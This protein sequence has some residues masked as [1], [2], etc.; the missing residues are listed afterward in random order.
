MF[1]MLNVV[2]FTNARELLCMKELHFLNA[3]VT[4]RSSHYHHCL[5]TDRLV[6]LIIHIEQLPNPKKPFWWKQPLMTMGDRI[7]FGPSV[8]SSALIWDGSQMKS[9]SRSLGKEGEMSW[10]E[11]KRRK[12]LSAAAAGAAESKQLYLIY[13]QTANYSAL[14]KTVVCSAAVSVSSAIPKG[15]SWLC[16]GQIQLFTTVV[17]LQQEETFRCALLLWDVRFRETKDSDSAPS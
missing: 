8:S 12:L 6:C 9:N 4:A 15:L 2:L 7:G 16:F 13:N 11:S 3:W 1:L 17:F 5:L 14:I 10:Q